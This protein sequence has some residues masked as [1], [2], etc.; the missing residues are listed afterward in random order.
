MPKLVARVPKYANHKRSGQAVVQFGGN[1]YYLGPYG[2]EES[3]REY[4]R[5]IAEYLAQG[6]RAS[7]PKD[8]PPTVVELTAAF[9]DHAT[10]YY[11][12]DG[13]P[14]T[15]LRCYR[16]VIADLVALYA[17][18]PV[19]EFGPLSLKAVRQRWIDRGQS[20]KTVNKNQ[21]RLVRIFKWGAGEEIVPGDVWQ[22]LQA[23]S[24]LRKGRSPAPEPNPIPPVGLEQ[25]E[26]TIPH[27][28]TV[29]AAMV[30]VQLLTGARP[31]EVCAMRP[32]DIDRSG[33]VWEYRPGSHKTEHHGR[34]RTIYIGPEAQVV[35]RPFLLRAADTP[36]F[37]AEESSEWFR[38]QA[39]ERRKTPPNQGNARGRKLD[40]RETTAAN[41]R[42][43]GIGSR[44]ASYGK[45]IRRA[46]GK[47]WPPPKEIKKDPAALKA[48][49]NEHVW[50]P[51]QLRHTRATEIRQRFGLEAAQVILGHASADITQVYAERDAAKAREVALAMG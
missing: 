43:P 10:K 38:E 5:V 17:D 28:S 45:A 14:T 3:V 32:G 6:R 25:V 2:S 36:C 13:E 31:G 21:G 35:L 49:C 30:R 12:K 33:D 8:E 7:G 16:L 15:E 26:A 4:D 48:W 24:G 23:L 51:N 27:L 39:E 29:V 42:S 34:T 47:A 41:S 44:Q 11:V 50:R 18:T 9:L 37:S 40:K 1:T 19:T 46:C 22:A 20:R